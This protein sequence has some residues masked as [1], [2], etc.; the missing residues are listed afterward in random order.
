MVR[1]WLDSTQIPSPDHN[2]HTHIRYHDDE[3]YIGLCRIYYNYQTAATSI[4]GEGSYG[5]KKAR[6]CRP[7]PVFMLYT[8]SEEN[9]LDT[10]YWNIWHLV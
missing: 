4:P 5:K 3:R 10:P 8:I 1:A 9:L 7:E 2:G 6:H